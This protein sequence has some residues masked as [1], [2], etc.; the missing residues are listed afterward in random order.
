MVQFIFTSI[1]VFLI[2]ILL[3][4]TILLI[5]KRYLSPSGNVS[6]NIN[7]KTTI[8]VPQGASLMSTLTENGI[9]LPSACGGKSSCRQCR[10]Q[11][12]E[13]GGEILDSENHTL[14]VSK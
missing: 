11:V 8:S 14:H 3:L 2:I 4:V 13:G 7:D 12:L 1:A 5:A 10:L 9:Y 6:I